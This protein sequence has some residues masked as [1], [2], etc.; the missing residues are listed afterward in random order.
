MFDTHDISGGYPMTSAYLETAQP[1]MSPG[2]ID[3]A[4]V[5]AGKTPPR[6]GRTFRLAELGCG[7]G[8]TLLALAATHPEAQFTGYDFNPEHI[9][10]ARRFAEEAGLSNVTFHEASFADLAS[11]PPT[12]QFDY[13]TLHG[14]WTWVSPENRQRIVEILDRWLA[15]GGAVY[16]SYN[17]AAGWGKAAPIR[18]I[19]NAIPRGGPAHPF[20]AARAAVDAWL[21]RFGDGEARACWDRLSRLPDRYLTHELGARHGT[22][23][24]PGDVAEAL[25]A[26][27]LD[28]VSPADILERFDRLR[29]EG[30]GLAFVRHAAREGWGE[31]AR[32]LASHRT[33]RT[34]IFARGA[35][36]LTARQVDARLGAL[37]VE[38]WP[39]R[40]A[41]ERGPDLA[42][43]AA[44]APEVERRAADLL[45]RGAQT[46]GEFAAAMGLPGRQGGQT[47]L[48]L[49]ARGDLR[50]VRSPDDP[51]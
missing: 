43:G 15:P 38:P 50:V 28:F 4:M 12:A 2:A 26:A 48:I 34:D 41:I 24:W 13:I 16:V 14:I 30:E 42:A 44:L 33:F 8:F 32:D 45:A 31:T 47:A 51:D 37:M 7:R 21:E 49:L 35:P 22:A 1:L 19:F 18:A 36:S 10:L 6:R 20:E 40:L 3:L 9:A 25:A 29:F 27:R 23:L 39:P 17:A 46:I 5:V 11:T